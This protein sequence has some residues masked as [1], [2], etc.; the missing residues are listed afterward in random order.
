MNKDVK[1]TLQELLAARATGQ[2]SRSERIEL[3]GLLA[4]YPEEDNENFELTASA[5]DLAFYEEDM[6]MPAELRQRV[7]SDA[8]VFF[9]DHAAVESEQEK[10][11]A[12]VVKMEKPSRRGRILW[13]GWLVAAAVLVVSSLGWWPL[14]ESRP[15][16]PSAAQRRAM[17]LMSNPELKP[18]SWS[19][20]GDEAGPRAGGDV[21]WDAEA[22]TGFMR[23]SGLS[24]NDPGRV[25]YQLWIFDKDRDDRYP[26]D[27]GVFDNGDAE[28]IARRGHLRP[29]I[30]VLKADE[31]YARPTQNRL[32][33]T[34]S[35]PLGRASR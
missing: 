35:H 21:V 30:A 26:I 13:S 5:I 27:G 31:T 8:A 17:L 33:V 24:A 23:F 34:P 32:R 22:Q 4:R 11:S 15:G 19:A 18:L 28:P 25:Q 12:P 6:S 10:V 9:R 29:D 2:L 16:P 7:A 1:K 14:I 20:T 3:E